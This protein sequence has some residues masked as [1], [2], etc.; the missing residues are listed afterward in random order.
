MKK[1]LA[2]TTAVIMTAAAIV[3]P[4]R[5][6]AEEYGNSTG[7]AVQNN[8]SVE[9]TNSL[10]S[11]LASE[12]SA[13]QAEQEENNGF[14][15]FSVE[16][17]GKI[18]T[19]ELET[20]DDAALVVGIYSEDGKALIAS[21]NADVTSEDRTVS[22]EIKANTMPEYYYIKAF[23]ADKSSLRPLC[24]V[25]ENPNYTKEMQEFFAK[26]VDDFAEDKVLNLD[27]DPDSNFLVYNDGIAVIPETVGVIR[28]N[29]GNNRAVVELTGIDVTA[30][31]LETGGVISYTYGGQIYIE[32]IISVTE[33]AGTTAVI[34]T[35]TDTKKLDVEN[36]FSYIKIDSDA[37]AANAAV[38]RAR[39]NRKDEESFVVED[40][41]LG[42]GISRGEPQS[43]GGITPK[44]SLSYT[45]AD[46][47]LAE[48]SN[49]DPFSPLETEANA[50]LNGS[51]NIILQG[52]E[53]YYYDDNAKLKY[54][55]FKGR[56]C[57]SEMGRRPERKQVCSL[58]RA[59]RGIHQRS[60]R[61]RS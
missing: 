40:G 45:F 39:A 49:D 46:I 48:Y 26:T 3:Q 58:Q 37:Y 13:K 53:D 19:V 8:L 54:M 44:Y 28:S 10:G 7:T 51:V 27:N 55:E 59:Q 24:T 42:N 1:L 34:D 33:S 50:K 35:D 31:G 16:M 57:K 15:V 18:A 47:S 9:G 6:S 14:N 32:K 4:F 60:G 29:S 5:V 22:V 43:I 17:N 25:Y 41:T 56:V 36:I 21:G 30:A 20:L 2:L 23:L 11:M 61:H 52:R 12:F 38:S